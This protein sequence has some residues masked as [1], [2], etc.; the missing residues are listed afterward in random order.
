MNILQ[1]SY[2]YIKD[3]RNDI[4]PGQSYVRGMEAEKQNG[5]RMIT[6][7]IS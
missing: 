1:L 4:V 7:V 2:T 5:P 3:S 6:S